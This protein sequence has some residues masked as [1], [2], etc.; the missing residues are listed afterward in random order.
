[1]ASVRRGHGAHVNRATHVSSSVSL[2]FGAFFRFDVRFPS[3]DGLQTNNFCDAAVACFCLCF[4]ILFPPTLPRSSV[5]D[6]A[7]KK[8]QKNAQRGVLDVADSATRARCSLFLRF[9]LLYSFMSF[10]FSQSCF[11]AVFLS[12][13]FRLPPPPAASVQ[14]GG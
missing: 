4:T 1:V 3:L 13:A 7:T 11:R 5:Q 6:T 9:L 2:S 14:R 8:R 10:L 12:A